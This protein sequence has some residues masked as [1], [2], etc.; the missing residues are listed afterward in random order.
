MNKTNRVRLGVASVALAGFVGVGVAT[1][2]SASPAP[3]SRLAVAIHPASVS[4]GLSVVSV[5]SSLAVSVAP[6]PP[7]VAAGE[8]SLISE[9]IKQ[10]LKHLGKS[11]TW[12]KEGVKKGYSWFKTNVWD[13]IP[14]WIKFIMGWAADAYEVFQAVWGY[15]F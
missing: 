6:T 12:L 11:Y 14:G 5:P 10:A 15:F 2:A 1:P 4:T 7:G 13:K 3:T 9:F 8:Q